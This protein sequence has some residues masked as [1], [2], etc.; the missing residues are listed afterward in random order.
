MSNSE[1]PVDDAFLRNLTEYSEI[2]SAITEGM[3]QSLSKIGTIITAHLRVYTD[4]EN[5]YFDSLVSYPAD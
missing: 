4:E 3:A 5:A 1:I 2:R